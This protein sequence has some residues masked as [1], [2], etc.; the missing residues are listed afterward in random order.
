MSSPSLTLEHESNPF[1]DATS[2][3]SDGSSPT[4]TTRIPTSIRLKLK[5]RAPTESPMPPAIPTDKYTEDVLR[6]RY[7]RYK[8]NA[9]EDLELIRTSGIKF[10]LANPPEDITENLVKFIIRNKLSDASC[11]WAR[12]AK[13]PGD[14]YSSTQKVIEA[15]SFTS[16]GP[17]SFGP[18]KAFNVIYFLDMRAW[19]ADRI[20][21]WR[22]N[23]TNESPVWKG[24]KMNATQT[25]DDQCKQ[26]RRPHIGWEKLYEQLAE[27]T[28]LIYDGT[29]EGTFL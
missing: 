19:L 10:R 21:L 23:L 7:M 11:V 2:T 14:L 13:L 18:E 27:H 17:C 4:M 26:G 20:V 5:P 28:E 6:R 12:E 24:M 8:T 29:F 22:V 15:K 16:D 25:F 1:D 9:L 3:T